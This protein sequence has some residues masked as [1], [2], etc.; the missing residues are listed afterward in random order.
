MRQG[1]GE[2]THLCHIYFNSATHV[3]Y[4]AADCDGLLV[5]GLAPLALQMIIPKTLLS[6]VS[7]MAVQV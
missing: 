6:K 2:L 1:F 5:L 3:L 7:E 4:E